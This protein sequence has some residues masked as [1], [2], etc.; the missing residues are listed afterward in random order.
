MPVRVAD[1]EGLGK[2]VNAVGCAIPLLSA[3][4]R[5]WAP[6]TL[7]HSLGAITRLPG[8]WVVGQAG[9]GGPP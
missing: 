3:L 4:D 2:R 1:V 9:K 6:W 7:G 5:G 8:A